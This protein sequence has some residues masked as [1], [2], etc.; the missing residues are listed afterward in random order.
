[1]QDCSVMS[2]NRTV[3]RFAIYVLLC[4]SV[5]L[6]ALALQDTPEPEVSAAPDMTLIA[7]QRADE[8]KR[9]REEGQALKRLAQEQESQCYQRFAVEDCLQ[10]ARRQ[11]RQ[12][13]ARLRQREIALNDQERQ[14]RADA[15]R[16]S[17]SQK[18]S[19]VATPST[20]EEKPSP[21][22]AM[23]PT[24]QQQD[25][26]AAERALRQQQKQKAA[27][28]Q[29]AKRQSD[30]ANRAKAARERQAEK[31][32]AAQERQQRVQDK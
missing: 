15:K 25:Q 14:E 30:Q 26:A 17:I 31:L 16:Q 1:M 28:A 2:C 7:Q 24:T 10:A 23:E 6:P 11:Q 12:S 19:Q 18:Q 8:R 20:V 22:A 27:Q 13:E 4:C 29:Q 9:L 3:L 5:S 21:I 32:K